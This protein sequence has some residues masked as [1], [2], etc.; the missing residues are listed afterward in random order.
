MGNVTHS[1]WLSLGIWIAAVEHL[2]FNL[3]T[4]HTASGS[5]HDIAQITKTRQSLNSIQFSSFDKNS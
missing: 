2:D 3:V 1:S 4:S 5:F